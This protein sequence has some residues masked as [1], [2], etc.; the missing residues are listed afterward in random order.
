MLKRTMSGIKQR[1]LQLDLALNKVRGCEDALT[2]SVNH[3]E[4]ASITESIH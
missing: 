1:T 2:Y 3:S 4:W